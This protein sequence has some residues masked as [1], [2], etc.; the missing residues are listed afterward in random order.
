MQWNIMGD[1]I[2]VCRGWKWAG[3]NLKLCL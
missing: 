1:L 3:Q 2:D